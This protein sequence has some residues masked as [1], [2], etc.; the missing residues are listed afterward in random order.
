[1]K[2]SAPK[3]TPVIKGA[4]AA[5][6]MKVGDTWKIYINASDPEGDMEYILASVDQ[7]GRGGGYPPSATKIRESRNQ[8]LSG[9]IYLSTSRS[10]QE[11]I[12]FTNITLTVQIKDRHGNLSAPVSF[13]LHFR[14][15]AQQAP[16]PPGQFEEVD[17]GPVMIEIS[18]AT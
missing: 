10:L 8:Q 1:M 3:P 7:P 15:S 2:D 14:S 4:Y 11:G 18:P 12:E 13:P 16:P 6:E 17:L 5:K 9:Y